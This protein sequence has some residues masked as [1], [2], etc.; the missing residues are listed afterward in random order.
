[1]DHEIFFI[2]GVTNGEDLMFKYC[3]FFA[4]KQ[5]EYCSYRLYVY[6]HNQYSVTSNLEKQALQYYGVF[7]KAW[8]G[9]MTW[10]TKQ[11][12]VSESAQMIEFARK[13]NNCTC[14]YAAR[15]YCAWHNGSFSDFE[16]EIINGLLLQRFLKPVEFED[17]A[18]LSRDY[19]CLINHPK[20]F[21]MKFYL[22]GIRD[23]MKE[24]IKRL[25]KLS[26]SK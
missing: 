1:M 23:E 17:D 19:K 15:S 20:R 4:A 21:Y 26:A 8:N 18:S 24:Y 16:R 10:L 22:Q 5:I 11:V 7:F 12:S 9:L 14:M 3:A 2:P 25:I 6:R 13:R